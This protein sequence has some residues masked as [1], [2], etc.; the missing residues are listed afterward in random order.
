MLLN[1]CINK[2]YIHRDLKGENVMIDAQGFIRLSD[3]GLAD[4]LSEKKEGPSV[5][6]RMFM[7]PEMM[8]NET[9]AIGPPV[10]WWAFG[11]LLY[12][13]HYNC[14]PFADEKMFNSEDPLKALIFNI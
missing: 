1:V 4:R 3:F 10:D 14:I 5:G 11:M 9:E 7:S 6:S 2:G 13:L 8:M 12:E